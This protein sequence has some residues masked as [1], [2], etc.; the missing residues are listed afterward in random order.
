MALT[1]RTLGAAR[2]VQ[3][4]CDHRIC[5]LEALI[6]AVRMGLREGTL[7]HSLRRSS[8]TRRPGL[9]LSP[10]CLMFPLI[11]R[12]HLQ[13]AGPG[14]GLTCRASVSPPVHSGF[15][16]P[17]FLRTF[18]P[19]RG[20]QIS[21]SL[22]PWILVWRKRHLPGASAAGSS[23]VQCNLPACL[24]RGPASPW[25]FGSGNLFPGLLGPSWS[26]VNANCSCQGLRRAP[27]PWPTLSDASETRREARPGPGGSGGQA[28]LLGV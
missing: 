28:S 24:P 26:L 18:R 10:P 13:A 17:E 22:L 15:L 16:L 27:S 19:P 1:P 4:G 20:I 12:S 7:P 6:F 3:L 21:P 11:T 5:I 9:V 23:G 8:G 2:S 14:Q 25:A